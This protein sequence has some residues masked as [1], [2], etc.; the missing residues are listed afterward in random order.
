MNKRKGIILAGGSGTR[1]YPVTMAVSKQLLPIYDKPMIYYPLSTL[2]L[3]GIR[4]ILIISTPQD[5]PRFEQ[6]LGDGSQWGLNL[7]YKVQPSPDGLA[8]AFIL[9]EEFIGGDD[10]AL[11]LGDNIFYGHDLQKQLEAAAAKPA[12]ATVFAY[13]VH[14]PERYGV[15]EFDREGTAISLEEKPLEPKSNYAVTGLYFYDNRVVEIAKSLKPSPRG[16]L[17]ITDV[18]RIY[19]EQGDLSVAMMGRGYAWLDTGTHE[20]LIEASNFIQTIETRQGLKVACPEEIAYR[21]KFIDADQVRK[22][23]APLAKNAYGQYLLKM[24][25]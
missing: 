17:E 18:N 4:D 1:L 14:D 8:Q 19:L 10:C 16:E 6:L 22:L 5:T 24:L 21:L 15:V 7:Q 25:K 20:S 13:H 23:A 11:V 12:G 9:G 3:A 2:M